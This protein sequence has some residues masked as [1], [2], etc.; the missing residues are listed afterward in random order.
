[1]VS[2]QFATMIGITTGMRIGGWS[3]QQNLRPSSFDVAS[4]LAAARRGAEGYM[5]VARR[6]MEQVPDFASAVDALYAA[7][8][9][10]PQYFILAGAGPYEGAVLTIDREGQ[11]LPGT[12]L[13][14]RLGHR[15]GGWHLVQTN[16]DLYYL[17]RDARRPFINLAL[18]ASDQEQVSTDFVLQ[19]LRTFPATHSMTVYTWVAVPASGFHQTTLNTKQAVEMPQLAAQ[20]RGKGGPSRGLRLRA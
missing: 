10:A 4:T 12:P 9:M 14:Q 17:P 2:V 19:L 18:A 15:P 13:V 6:V 3:F 1:M 5:L 16:D 8:L 11:H 20:P 7:N